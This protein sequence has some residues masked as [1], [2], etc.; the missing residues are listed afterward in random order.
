MGGGW[1]NRGS[2]ARLVYGKAVGGKV[3]DDDGSDQWLSELNPGSGSTG[4][5]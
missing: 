5:Q 4:E 2:L 3:V 1:E